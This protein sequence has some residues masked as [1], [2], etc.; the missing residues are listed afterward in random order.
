LR[1]F[2]N[3]PYAIGLIP[4]RVV[5]VNT[6]PD[7]CWAELSKYIR[8]KAPTGQWNIN[9]HLMI[10]KYTLTWGCTQDYDLPLDIIKY[11]WIELEF[12]KKWN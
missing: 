1:D 10:R 11:L 3:L 8:F 9:T 12:L 7:P 4:S 5:K 2:V 6:G